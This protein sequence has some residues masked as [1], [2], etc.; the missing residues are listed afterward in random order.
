M[1]GATDAQQLQYA[2]K[3]QRTI[4]TH[5][6]AD[7]E[8]LAKEYFESNRSHNGII[9]AVRRPPQLVA[10]RLLVVLND[11]TADEMKEQLRY[12]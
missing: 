5:N 1:T 7:F 6:R 11:T 10:R 3:V 8:R 9:I 12:I 4:L 2:A